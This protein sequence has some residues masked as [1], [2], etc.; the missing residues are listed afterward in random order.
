MT[1]KLRLA[2]IGV[3]GWLI[4]AGFG[5]AIGAMRLFGPIGS[6]KLGGGIAAFIGPHLSVSRVA[7]RNIALALP[8]ISEAERRRIVREAWHNL[9]SVVGEFA[10]LRSSGQTATGPGWEIVGQDNIGA[11]TKDGRPP[12]FFSAHFGNWEMIL[13]IAGALNLP[14]AG[15]YR[16]A[17]NLA[18]E[19]LV[20]GI[21]GGAG[22]GTKMFAKGPAGARAIMRHL[23]SG[24]TL[25]LL[26]DQKMNDG[27]AVPF[28]GHDAWT[29]PALAQ[30][31]TRFEREIVPI[32]VLR[33]GPARYRMIC[34]PALVI[35]KS[36]GC[37][38]D[39]VA[40]MTAV[41]AQVE[42]WIRADP[43]QWLWFH[44][45]WPKVLTASG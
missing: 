12:I 41:N 13:P 15:V 29:A 2:G 8:D 24:G 28:F 44:R 5:A 20:Q 11:A 7:M 35:A 21:R 27:I 26:V 39:E 33:I 25:G 16:A 42:R 14:V 18:L 30:L 6:S 38:C 23:S 34:E 17:S 10:H 36:A 31:A 43:G 1:S 32:R 3:T 9:G 22:H 45:R 4:G 37:R 40:I 19:Q